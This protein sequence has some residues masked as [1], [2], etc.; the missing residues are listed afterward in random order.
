MKELELIQDWKDIKGYEG[1]YKISNYG[2]VF[3]CKSRKLVKV[4]KA[5]RS[6][7][8]GNGYGYRVCLYKDKKYKQF[9]IGKL[10]AEHFVNNPYNYKQI[11]YIDGNPGNYKYTNIQWGLTSKDTKIVVDG[12]IF[13]SLKE[14]KEFCKRNQQAQY[15]MNL[16]EI[17][18]VKIP[19][20]QEINAEFKI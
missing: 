18:D 3:N 2:K 12:L 16:N 9:G 8:T 10:V 6:D 11:Y 4:V 20:L 7:N 14:Y 13:N 19:T 15:L 1:L 17:C 5:K